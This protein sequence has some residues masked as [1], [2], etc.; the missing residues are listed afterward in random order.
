[1]VPSFVPALVVESEA[2]ALVEELLGVLA[3]ETEM[4]EDS[5]EMSL[6]AAG[7]GN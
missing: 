1:L 4:V 2:L 5:V 3:E 7:T 6:D